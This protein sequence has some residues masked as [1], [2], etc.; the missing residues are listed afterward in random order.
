M[1]TVRLFHAGK[2]VAKL[3]APAIPALERAL[4]ANNLQ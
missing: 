3:G 1:T 4:A 2:V